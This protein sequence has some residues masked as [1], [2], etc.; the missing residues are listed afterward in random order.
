MRSTDPFHIHRTA[1]DSLTLDGTAA[2][3]YLTLYPNL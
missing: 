2:E 3:I 1:A